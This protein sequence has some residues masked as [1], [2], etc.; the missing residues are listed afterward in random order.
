MSTLTISHLASER[1]FPDFDLYE[2]SEGRFKFNF[3]NIHGFLVGR[4]YCLYRQSITRH[5]YIRILDNIVRQVGKKDIKDELIGYVKEKYTK[6]VYEN[7]LKN[8]GRIVHDEFL[9]NLPAKDVE[10]LKDTKEEI[11]L[12]YV[13]SIVVISK[14]H[15][16]LLDYTELPDDVFIWESQ[17]IQRDFNLKIQGKS[18][19]RTFCSNIANGEFARI[20][21]IQTAIGYL[22]H[23]Y[24]NPALCPAII[25]NDEVISDNPEGGTGKSLLVKS[26]E[27]FTR[28]VTI[29]GKTFSFDKNFTYQRIDPDT[30]I[31]CFQDVQKNFDFERLFS[32][33]TDGIDVEKK[34]KDS[35]FIS[36]QDAPKV[37]IT[38]NYAVRG[39]G[40]SHERRR[41]ELEISQHYNK[42]NTP[43]KEF[44]RMLFYEWNQEDWQRFDLFMAE[45]C[46]LYLDLGLVDQTLVNLPEKRLLAETSHEF[47]EFMEDYTPDSGSQINRVEFYKKFQSENPTSKIASKTFYRYVHTYCVF[48]SVVCEERK[49]NGIRYFF[50]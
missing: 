8:T 11:R 36:F 45:C 35:T 43:D 12:F 37:V 26:I 44:G 24:K 15:I 25:L 20:Q 41:F 46:Q 2:Y 29:E 16:S 27:K 18:E 50:F 1:V 22:I 40:N 21:S 19:F 13:N 48:Y 3:A 7:F 9:E 42:Q 30:R 49:S 5:I 14:N 28:T 6:S 31:L 39:T 10:F 47:I 4:G 23:N 33:I 34:G 17:I 32:V 38:T